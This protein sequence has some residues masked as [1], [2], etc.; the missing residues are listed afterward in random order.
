MPTTP[1]SRALLQITR[2]VSM[3]LAIAATLALLLQLWPDATPTR[4]VASPGLAAE[5]AS[6]D[7]APPPV[8]RS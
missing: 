7:P 1:P 4:I 6:A 3:A 5:P 2:L 8:E